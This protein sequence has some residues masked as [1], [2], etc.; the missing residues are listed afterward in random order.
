M[1]FIGRCRGT[2]TNTIKPPPPPPPLQPPV[3]TTN[4]KQTT[5]PPKPPCQPH[6]H[7]QWEPILSFSQ[8]FLLKSN[9]VRGW[10]PHP[11][12]NK[13]GTPTRLASSHEENPGSATAVQLD[14]K[15]TSNG[16]TVF[17]K[18]QL[19][20]DLLCSPMGNY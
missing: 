12:I 4:P 5:S 8:M 13:I 18:R 6:P 9:H 10:Q 20:M 19:V 2:L 11:I 7:P 1:Q 14:A 15:A 3:P 17:P 16:S